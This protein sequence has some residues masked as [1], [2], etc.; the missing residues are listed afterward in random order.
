M[1]PRFVIVT[2]LVFALAVPTPMLGQ[3]SKAEKDI[4][5]VMEQLKQANLSG[6]AEGATIFDKYYAD[7]YAR[8]APNGAIYNKAETIDANRKGSQHVEAQDLS[9]VKVRIYRNT[10]VVTGILD[11]KSAGPMSGGANLELRQSRFT[12]VFVKR[13][14]NWSCVLYQSTSITPPKTETSATQTKDQLVGTWRLIS[15]KLTILA[16]GETRDMFGKAPQGYIIYGRDGR[17]MVLFVKD[18]RPKP[19]SLETMTDQERANLFRT[20]AAYSG[21]YDFDGKEVTHHIDVSWNQ[22]WTGTD[23]VRKVNFEGKRLVLTTMPAP[24]I[25]DGAMGV[26]VLTWEKVD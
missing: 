12:R 24:T 16:T 23:Q 9:D 19:R 8:I 15:H 13:G 22:I 21:T 14:G 3:Q 5:A 7:D 18:E 17:M 11:S 20:M 4:R 10:A 26:G 6:G 2:L 1:K 25:V